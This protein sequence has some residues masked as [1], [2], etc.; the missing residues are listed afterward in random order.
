MIFILWPSSIWNKFFKY[1]SQ[2]WQTQSCKNWKIRDI[3]S[4]LETVKDLRVTCIKQLY[5]LGKWYHEGVILILEWSRSYQESHPTQFPSQ[6]F[7]NGNKVF[8]LEIKYLFIRRN[9]QSVKGLSIAV[10]MLLS[11]HA[12]VSSHSS[13]ESCNLMKV[14]F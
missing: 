2:W 6:L 13:R 3:L 10:F 1:I 8:K 4:P 7:F 11:K 9:F 5:N 14:T 12:V